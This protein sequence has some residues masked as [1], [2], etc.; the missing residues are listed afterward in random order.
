MQILISHASRLEVQR[1]LQPILVTNDIHYS[2]LLDPQFPNDDV[3]H[4]AVHVTPGISFAQLWKLDRHCSLRL[5][6]HTLAPE[7]QLRMNRSV[8]GKTFRIGVEC[9]NGWMMRYL[10]HTKFVK[11]AG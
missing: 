8:E 6:L 5:N 10:Q 1:R 9:R 4:A 7:F 2:V 3:V 11:R